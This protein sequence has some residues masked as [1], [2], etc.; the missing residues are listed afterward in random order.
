MKTAVIYW[1]STGN[2]E[3]M[4]K[5]VAEGADAELYAVSEFKGNIEEYDRIAFGCSAMGVEELDDSEFEPFF[6]SIES[7]LSGKKIALFGSYGWGDGEYMR[8]WVERAKN[9]GADVLDGEGLLI[10]ETP[11]D[12]ELEICKEFGA[13]LSSI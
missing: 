11:S 4:A 13:K 6:S 8:K 5:A 10:N 1:S 3:M 7:R 2:T 12:D 9:D